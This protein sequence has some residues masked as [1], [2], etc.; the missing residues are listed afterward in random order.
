MSLLPALPAHNIAA[1]LPR[2][3]RAQPYTMA[4]LYP[5]G[6][7]A[8]G[9]VAYTHLTYAQLDHDSDVIA[10][11]LEAVGIKRGTRTALMVKPSLEFFAL[12]FAIF[13]VGAV[14][15]L[16]DP[17]IGLRHLKACLAEAAPEAFIGIPAAHAARVILRWGRASI[18]T[19]VTVG[20]RLFW[21]GYSLE[22]V[23][24]KGQS[25][26]PYA[27]A[28]TQPE[29]TAAILFTSGATGVP[30]GAVYAHRTFLAQVDLIRE[31]YD[32]QPGEVDLPT[33]PL[34]ALFD[35]A[36]GMTTIVPDMDFTRPA[37]VDPKKLLAA[38]DD[39]GVTNMFGS[40]ALLDTVGRYAAAHGVR[41]PSLKRI[42]SAGAPMAPI[43]L[44]RMSTL[45]RPEAAIHTPYGAT[46][47]LPVASVDSHTLLQEARPRTEAGAGVCIGRT[48][49]GVEL[50]IIRITDAPIAQW[51]D[52]LR[53]K[54]GE[55]G[56]FVVK[57][58]VVTASYL[59]RPAATEAAKIRE[60]DAVLH[61]MGDLGYQDAE[62]L[63]WFCGRKA[64]RVETAQGPL[65]TD[66]CEGV[67]NAHPAV[68][69]SALVG[70]PEEAHKRP[71][72][73]IE[74][75][76]PAA[77]FAALLPALRAL[78]AAQPHTA[79]I[80]DI[81]HHKGA[82]PVDIRHNAKINR[83]ALARWAAAEEKKR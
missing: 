38:I 59:N 26:A 46:E 17:G 65:Y 61:R 78:G 53:V 11:G 34:F 7:D 76:D 32:I 36:L 51:S 48:V 29:E 9:K 55:I 81:R 44:E 4:V 3:A 13:K 70:I 37:R 22:E 60:G 49:P 6:K 8:M 10:R 80:S 2:Q 14:P 28:D 45:L 64:H 41:R 1:W 27:M 19:L 74:L 69:R 31:T 25:E 52:D 30:K 75:E 47:A 66:P 62:G 24:R 5:Q 79:R 20:P 35:P 54:P 43:I 67:F 71:A 12:T 58:P 50:R 82:F 18:R 56:E 42:I 39:F 40:P 77:D 57:G 73:L 21:G 15:V 63:L 23:K 33:F 68:R 16:I 72:M 83:E